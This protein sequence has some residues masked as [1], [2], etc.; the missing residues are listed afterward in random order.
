MTDDIALAILTELRAIRLALDARQQPAADAAMVTFV[1]AV[2]ASI[3]P[4]LFTAGDLA[5][6]AALAGSSALRSAILG[7]CRGLG[8]RPLG[9]ALRRLEGRPMA[10]LR[11]ERIGIERDGVVWRVAVIAVSST[12][13][14]TLPIAPA[15]DLVACS[16]LDTRTGRR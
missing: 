9:R 2:H 16:A 4:R 3:G 8:A 6:H 7:V 11:V 13:V 15:T 1:R 14:T 10:G 5:A 12:A